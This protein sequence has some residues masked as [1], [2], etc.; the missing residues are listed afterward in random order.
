MQSP[1]G[2]SVV[3]L[4]ELPQLKPAMQ[5]TIVFFKDSKFSGKWSGPALGYL[6]NNFL[7]K[8]NCA[9]H[10][11]LFRTQPRSDFLMLNGSKS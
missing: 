7:P 3:M 11:F 6:R 10:V 2:L 8:R 9:P 4:F 1:S 5:S